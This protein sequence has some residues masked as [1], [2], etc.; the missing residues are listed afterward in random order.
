MG[1]KGNFRVKELNFKKGDFSLGD[2]SFTL[3][4]GKILAVVGKS[5]SGKS[6]L[7]KTIAG[8]HETSRGDIYLGAKKIDS[9]PPKDRKLGYVFENYALFPNMDTEENIIFP[10]KL[11][12]KDKSE[13]EKS[14]I[15]I[16]EEIGIDKDYLKDN[17]DQ[18]PEGVKQLVSLAKAKV[19]DVDIMLLDEP[20]TQLD[21][22]TKNKMKVFLKKV[23]KRYNLT[24]IF[25]LN[26]IEI[27][28]AL[29]DYLCIIENGKLIQY[30]KTLDV[31]NKPKSPLALE[32]TSKI[33][34]NDMVIDIKDNI[35]KELNYEVDFSNIEFSGEIND[36]KY[37]FMFRV[38]EVEL[39]EKG[40]KAKM[41]NKN[42]YSH[43]KKLYTC[44][45][46]NGEEVKLVLPESKGDELRFRVINPFIFGELKN[47]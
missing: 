45:L 14:L 3:P 5:G 9:L 21:N 42:Y 30:G 23:I 26:D 2:I 40:I 10:L 28:M 33:G 13:Q 12:H 43:D 35:I 20:F 16:S 25:A 36:G 15:K 7:L 38:E 39:D 32:I 47:K 41:I 17:I 19:R 46:E 6:L 31:Y 18:L 11:H 4:K 29:S 37:R 44:I 24:A 34:V 22:E 1:D 27:A 8:L